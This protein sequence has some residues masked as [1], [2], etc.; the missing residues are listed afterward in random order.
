[1]SETMMFVIFGGVIIFGLMATVLYYVARYYFRSHEEDRELA[2][3]LRKEVESEALEQKPEEVQPQ[4]EEKVEK[5]EPPSPPKAKDLREALLN[6]RQTLWGRVSQ[7]FGQGATLSDESMESLEEILYTSDLGP[8][9]V[10]RLVES[11]GETLSSSEKL[12]IE[13]VSAALRKEMMS[14]FNSLNYT[15]LDEVSHILNLNAEKSSSD[16]QVWMIVGV[17]GVGKTTTIGKLAYQVVQKG[18]KVMVVAGDT[19]RAA[20][21]EQLKVWSERAEVE[22]FHPPGVT[23]PSAVAFDACSSARSKNVDVVI[24]DTAGRLHTQDHLMKELEKMKRVVQKVLPEAPH[25]VF[26]VL[27]ANSGQNALVQARSFNQSV[28]LTGA[29]L[30]KLD[31][32]AKG[33]VAVGLACELKLP[34]KM[35]GVGE[36]LGDLQPFHSKEFVE[37]II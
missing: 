8:A 26:V 28:D 36:G 5:K 25:E 32:S 10:Q 7:V 16:P 34:I 6:T 15:E 20:A 9:T 29:I 23:D 24:I 1:M 17:N 19:F 21:G 18:Q 3:G 35:I 37:S 33:G 14:I 30:T 31:G 27:D 11:V 4:L 2:P 22:F 13:N 12:D